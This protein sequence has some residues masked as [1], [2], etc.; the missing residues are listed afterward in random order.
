V[1]RVKAEAQSRKEAEDL[2]EA[3]RIRFKGVFQEKLGL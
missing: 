3:F 2:L 1:G